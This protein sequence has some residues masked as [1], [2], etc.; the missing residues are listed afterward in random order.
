MGSGREHWRA[1]LSDPA[2]VRSAPSAA[3]PVQYGAMT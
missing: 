2:K 3:I 1:A